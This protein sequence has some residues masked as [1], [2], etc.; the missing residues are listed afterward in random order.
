MELRP[1]ATFALAL[2]AA[3]LIP[4]ASA[5]AANQAV[6]MKDDFFE[7]KRVQVDPG[8][9]VTWTNLGSSAHTATSRT[10]APAPFDSGEKD[11]LQAFAFT[12]TAP[13]RYSYLC[14]IH[15]GMVGVVQVGPDTTPPKLKGVKVAKVKRGAKSVKVSFGVNEDARV[16]A[17]FKRG[18]KS[19]KTLTSKLLT[20]DSGSSLRYK[21][22]KLK[23]GRYSVSLVATDQPA[24]NAS[25]PVKKSFK[26]PKR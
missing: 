24:G 26:V 4:A 19:V 13:G 16:K 20:E 23:P 6:S 14:T 11:P 9:T 18:K 15:F 3:A 12:F 1:R 10:G 22:R 2:I 25:K 5:G 21:P 8:D 17:T 7:P